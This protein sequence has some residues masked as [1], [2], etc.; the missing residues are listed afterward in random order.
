M[1]IRGLVRKLRPLEALAH[2]M[3]WA[4]GQ[5]AA[6]SSGQQEAACDCAAA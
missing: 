5:R 3:L 2:R 4:A 1:A 6:R